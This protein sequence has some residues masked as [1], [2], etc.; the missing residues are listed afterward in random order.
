[1][2][3]PLPSSSP[4]L[5]QRSDIAISV[6]V[7]CVWLLRLLPFIVGGGGGAVIIVF[8]GA[9]VIIIIFIAAHQLGVVRCD[10]ALLL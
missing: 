6:S 1:M 4:P 9:S 5:F 3:A 7:I 2:V 10:A 8:G